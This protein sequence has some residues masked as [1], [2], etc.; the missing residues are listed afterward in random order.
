MPQGLDESKSPLRIPKLQQVVEWLAL[1]L[2]AHIQTLHRQTGSAQVGKS[3]YIC[4]N[5][6]PHER[7]NLHM[8]HALPP[9]STDCKTKLTLTFEWQMPCTAVMG[10]ALSS[11]FLELLNF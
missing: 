11:G 1:L 8:F 7:T 4:T 2:D 3:N 10:H 5:H 9:H 6:M